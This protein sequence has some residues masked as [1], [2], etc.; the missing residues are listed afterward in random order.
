MTGIFNFIVFNF[1]PYDEEVVELNW[2]KRLNG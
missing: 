1:A 2:R